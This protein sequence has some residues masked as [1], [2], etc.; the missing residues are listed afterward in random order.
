M[1]RIFPIA[2]LVFLM[3]APGAGQAPGVLH[4]TVV[5][6]D[7]GRGTT[8][9]PRH[10]LLISDNPA[11][12]AP[13][14]VLTALDGTVSVTL[15]P[16]NYTVESDR[17]AVFHG[18][19]YQWTQIVD[20]VAGGTVRLELT[21]DNAEVETATA[22]TTTSTAPVESDPSFLLTDWQDSVVALWTPTTRASGFLVDARGLVATSQRAI[23]G[24]TGVEVQLTPAVK[25][26]ARVLAADPA[27]D[28]AVLWID[29]KSAASVRPVPLGCGLPARPVIAN[30]QEIFTIGVPMRGQKGLT[31]GTARV[32]PMSIEADFD[33]ESGTAGGPVFTAGGG[34]VGITTVV[35]EQRARRS[36]EV[37]VVRIDA[38]CAVVAAAETK[39]QGAPAPDGRP[40]PVEPSRPFPPDALG[41]A[42][43]GR[44]GSLNP[45]QMS[46]SDFDVAFITP[47]MTW[48]APHPPAPAGGKEPEQRARASQPEPPS[49]RPLRDFGNWSEYVADYPPVL[50][51]RVTPRLVEGFWTKVARAAASTQGVAVPPI[52]RFTSGF[53]RLRMFCGDAEVTPIHPFTLVQRVSESDAIYEGLY[54]FDPAALGPHCGPARLEL[55]SEKAPAKADSRVIDPKVLQQIWQDFTAYRAG[56]GH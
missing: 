39:M 3:S 51:V 35:D 45:Y 8:P 29:P 31:S 5:L 25:V 38:A 16:G 6:I 12:A 56:P 30:G 20:I 13:R 2:T 1:L 36:P 49:V 50:L 37:L 21:A 11:T 4:V 53:S 43:A 10:A 34:V 17:P 28:V 46:S 41:S 55:Y 23:G 44:A 26:A 48:A 27:R 32:S 52:K 42:A 40:L 19:A 9:V 24:A 54:V 18:K 7:A 22:A 15:R 14:R 33:V 47:V